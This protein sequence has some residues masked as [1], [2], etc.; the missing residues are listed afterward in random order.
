MKWNYGT[1]IVISLAC[2]Q[3]VLFGQAKQAL[4]EHASKGPMLQILD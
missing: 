2:E 4:Q 1:F 3:A